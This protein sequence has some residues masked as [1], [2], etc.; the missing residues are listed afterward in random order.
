MAG[1]FGENGVATT[2]GIH[3][4]WSKRGCASDSSIVTR[5]QIDWESCACAL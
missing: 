1:A 2:F 3:Y 4:K 5:I